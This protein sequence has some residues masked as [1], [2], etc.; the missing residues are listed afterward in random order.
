MAQKNF[1]IDRTLAEEFSDFCKQRG[2]T[3]GMAASAALLSFMKSNADD[4]EKMNLKLS[5]WLAKHGSETKLKMAAKKVGG[6]KGTRL[7]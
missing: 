4:R 5:Q 2:M 3:M 1:D 7:K 6:V